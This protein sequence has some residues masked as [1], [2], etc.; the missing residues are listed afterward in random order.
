MANRVRITDV[1]ESIPFDNS[2]NGYAADNVQDAIEEAQGA[3]SGKLADFLFHTSGNTS[4]KWLGLGSGSTPSNTLPLI[5]P[6]DG[7]LLWLT[8]SNEDNNVDIDVEIYVN[9]TIIQT[10]EVRNKRTGWKTDF[11]PMNVSQGDRV[12]CFLRRYNGGTGDN[13][14]QDPAVEVFFQFTEDNSDEGGTQH[15]V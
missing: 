1:A 7:Q 13:T 9:G 10:W 3:I 14:A 8:F 5:I 4:N 6:Q 2:S 15:G 12:S 11:V